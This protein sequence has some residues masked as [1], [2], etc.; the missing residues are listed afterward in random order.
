MNDAAAG[1]AQDATEDAARSGGQRARIAV[2]GGGAMGLSVAHELDKAGVQVEI[3]E[4]A[5]SFG[6]L[7]GAID[8]GPF[9]WDQFYH[10][11]LGT[12]QELIEMLDE[13]G[14]A[15]D[16]RWTETNSGFLYD[17]TRHSLG[18]VREFLGFEP[19]RFHERI[20][21]GAF[22]ALCPYL[23]SADALE[24]TTAS[25]FLQKTCGKRV[26]EVVW[27]PLLRAK[28]GPAGETISARFIFETVNRLNSARS[29][30][31]KQ[32]VLGYVRGGYGRILRSL[33]ADLEGRGVTLTAG[34]PTRAVRPGADGRIEVETAAGVRRFD[35]AVITVDNHAAERLLPE[36]PEI[37]AR[38]GQIEYLGVAVAG[39]VL[40]RKISPYYILNISDASIDVT[41]V[42]GTSNLVQDGSFGDYELFYLPR[43]LTHGDPAWANDEAAWE[44]YF[45]AQLRLIAPDLRDED[46]VSMRV[47]TARMVQPILDCD[48]QRRMPSPDIGVPGVWIANSSQCYQGPIHINLIVAQA[49]R[50]T[51]EVVRSLGASGASRA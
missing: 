23:F 2:I 13:I 11:I 37:K 46:V 48:Y 8:F 22:L 45:R 47:S 40:T 21:L 42:I 25:A 51:R 24:Q 34:A 33:L 50:V 36:S 19:L 43:Y 44:T 49:Q 6:G 35:Q 15:G 38:L 41:G 10:C 12:D 20:R 39:F 26:W 30:V 18:S 29:G 1:T 17:G 5:P 7:A 3:F 28:L 31:K 27:R 14:L 9:E 32:E 4:A 16:L